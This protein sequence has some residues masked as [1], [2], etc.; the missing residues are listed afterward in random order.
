MDTPN[1]SVSVIA[2]ALEHAITRAPIALRALLI[3]SPNGSVVGSTR[4][5]I[6]VLA[7]LDEAGWDLDGDSAIDMI[8]A[9][10]EAAGAGAV[11]DM[12]V[13]GDASRLSV[14]HHVVA[15]LALHGARLTRRDLVS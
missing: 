6:R 15:E 4:L 9:S 11:A 12:V 1:E 10:F 3:A 14:A 13:G 2:N 5:A 8:V 7:S